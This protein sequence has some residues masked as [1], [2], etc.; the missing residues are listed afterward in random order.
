MSYTEVKRQAMPNKHQI[1]MPSPFVVKYA[2]V[3]AI[4][5]PGP[6]ADVACGYGRNTKFFVDAGCHVYCI[7]RNTEALTSIAHKYTQ[8][9]VTPYEMDFSIQPWPF[10]PETL[11]AVINVHYYQKDLVECFAESLKP[12]GYLLIESIDGRGGNYLELPPEGFIKSKLQGFEL[13]LYQ[14]RR[15]GPADYDAVTCKVLARKLKEN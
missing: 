5:A 2:E 1:Q 10:K 11:G 7:D 8:E 15:V 3:I 9:Q 12:G 13:I 6:I 4:H 14:E